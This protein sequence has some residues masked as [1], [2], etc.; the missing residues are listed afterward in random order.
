MTEPTIYIE[1]LRVDYIN[2]APVSTETN[3]SITLPATTARVTIGNA[4]TRGPLIITVRSVAD[5]G[6]N[7]IFTLVRSS[8]TTVTPAKNNFCTMDG[9]NNE[10]IEFEWQASSAL[11]IYHSVIPTDGLT[12][13]Y[14]VYVNSLDGGF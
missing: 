6:A 10:R 14:V 13:N 5:G 9:S 4:N 3:H 11:S 1:S 2:G 8:T 7:G 12:K